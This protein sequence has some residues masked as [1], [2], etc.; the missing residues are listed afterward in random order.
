[1]LVYT[2]AASYDNKYKHTIF[3]VLAGVCSVQ[4]TSNREFNK[5]KMKKI[6]RVLS[7]YISHI[8]VSYHSIFCF[9]GFE[10][11]KWK[12]VKISVGITLI[13]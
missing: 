9:S 3:I 13:V 2:F 10:N 11:C 5:K 1:M 7:Y 6:P 4:F 12:L 8:L